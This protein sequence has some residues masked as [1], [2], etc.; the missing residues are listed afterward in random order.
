M[1]A[2]NKYEC[3]SNSTCYCAEPITEE[4]MEIYSSLKGLK[5]DERYQ[6]PSNHL[7]TVFQRL[8]YLI[9]QDIDDESA[10]A[11][12][13][14]SEFNSALDAII[15]FRSM[16]TAK[17][18]IE[19]AKS[20]LK[21]SDS[22]ESLKNFAYLPNYLQLAQTEYLGAGLSPGDCVLFLGS[23]P[24]PIS[25]IV[26]CHQ[27]GLRCIGIEQEPERAELSRR[28]LAKLELSDQ[29]RIVEGDHL[30]LPLEEKS[31]LI[32]VAAQAEPKKAIFDHLAKV[33]PAGTKVSYRIYDKG[34]RRLLDTFSRY[35]LPEPFE[36]YLRVRPKPPVNN[37]VVFLTTNNLEGYIST[38]DGQLSERCLTFNDEE[39]HDIT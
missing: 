13:S 25:L 32:M 31:E 35:E 12:L 1:A 36:E 28:V 20:I 23:G 27:Y 24:L 18:E 7:K 22:W 29:V 16:Y 14:N 2:I 8:D 4:I 33:L 39:M 5:D 9:A 10:E 15:R 3:L 30:T 19:H 11:I 34:L 37:T 21:S 6:D 26:L 38:T 17:L